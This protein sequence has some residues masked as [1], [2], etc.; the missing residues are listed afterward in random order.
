VLFNDEL[1]HVF[2][3]DHLLVVVWTFFHKLSILHRQQVA[4]LGSCLFVLGVD[5]FDWVF[6]LCDRE[7][8]VAPVAL[9]GSVVTTA[10]TTTVVRCLLVYLFGRGWEVCLVTAVI[11]AAV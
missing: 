11:G 9:C 6:L 4:R 5:N 2:A 7:M 3:H 10:P 8:L 1:T